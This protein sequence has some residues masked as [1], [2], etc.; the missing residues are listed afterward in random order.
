MRGDDVAMRSRAVLLRS[1]GVAALAAG[2][3]WVVK[4]A[5]ILV[6]DTQPPML[7]EAALPLFG[8]AV[9]C[10]ASGGRLSRTR[11]GAQ[12]AGVVAAVAGMVAV[13]SEL[14]GEARSAA[15]IVASVGF[16]SGL[17]LVGLANREEPW[18]DAGTV[19]LAFVL[20]LLTVPAVAVGGLLSLAAERLVE[21]PLLMLGGL[22]IWLGMGMLGRP[23]DVPAAE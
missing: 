17:V 19:R 4:S 10:V 16:V 23:R 13:V 2:T 9:A 8:V 21:L 14:L 7:F 1:G 15:L 5:T 12:M 20:G 18:P 22:W 3:M 6:V 11:L